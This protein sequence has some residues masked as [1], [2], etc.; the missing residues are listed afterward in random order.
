ML[1]Q[2]MPACAARPPPALIP[3]VGVGGSF[4]GVWPLHKALVS[5]LRRVHRELIVVFIIFGVI[6]VVIYVMM[7]IIVVL[8]FWDGHETGLWAL[9]FG[10]I[11]MSGHGL[12]RSLCIAS[13]EFCNMFYAN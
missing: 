7:L 5:D 12:L 1:S 2:Q 13:S 11:T 9:L 10:E 6:I 8:C 4:L 3:G